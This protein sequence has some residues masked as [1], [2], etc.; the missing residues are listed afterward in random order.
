MMRGA[1]HNASTHANMKTTG[2]QALWP[3]RME[4]LALLLRSCHGDFSLSS[5]LAAT[6]RG[7]RH[8]PS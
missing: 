3:L 5:K 1:L 7:A 4:P 2:R 8:K 6:G